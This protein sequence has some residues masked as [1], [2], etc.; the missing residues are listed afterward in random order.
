M[1]EK[2]IVSIRLETDFALKLKE[3]AEKNSR[4]LPNFIVFSLK[5]YV[6]DILEEEW[7]DRY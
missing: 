1:R 2:K 5:S 4:S 6:R 3:L 7:A